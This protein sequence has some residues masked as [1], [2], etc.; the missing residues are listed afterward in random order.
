MY[1]KR[2][3][4][5]KQ[6]FS[7]PISKNKNQIQNLVIV[8]YP[9]K[10]KAILSSVPNMEWQS[11]VGNRVHVRQGDH[12]GKKG[13]IVLSNPYNHKVE[14]DDGTIGSVSKKYWDQIGPQVVAR[15]PARIPY[16]V[17][18]P[19]RL[20]AQEDD[21]EVVVAEVME[22]VREE[23]AEAKYNEEMD[24]GHYLALQREVESTRLYAL[25]LQT[26]AQTIRSNNMREIALA[27]NRARWEAYDAQDGDAGDSEEY[28]SD[29]TGDEDD[30]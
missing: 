6:P 1:S 19:E 12:Q 27:A 17:A 25:G 23:H 28:S 29:E 3:G 9:V 4:F 18:L 24:L 26:E 20:H 2:F 5:P 13:S 7:Y 30:G 11:F 16:V 8:S 21:D 22:V 14:F 15:R 10:F